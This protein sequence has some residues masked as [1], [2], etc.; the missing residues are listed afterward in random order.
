LLGITIGTENEPVLSVVV[1][2]ESAAPFKVNVTLLFAAKPV[3]VTVIVPPGATDV[4]VL[5]T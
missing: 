5:V 1:V 3:P 2:V 4:G